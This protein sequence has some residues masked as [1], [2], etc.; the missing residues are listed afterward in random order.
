VEDEEFHRDNKNTEEPGPNAPIDAY[1]TY[2][3]QYLDFTLA[4][5][6]QVTIIMVYTK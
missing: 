1:M 6:R 4:K 3:R 2:L 5:T